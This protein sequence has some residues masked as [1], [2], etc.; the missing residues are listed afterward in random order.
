M[1]NLL[2]SA[3][4]YSIS[5]YGAHSRDIFSSLFFSQKFNISLVIP[6]WGATSNT[7][8]LS[9][10][11]Q[12]AIDFCAHN[13]IRNNSDFI[14]IHIGIPNEF[15]RLGS[16]SV[17]ITAGLEC[18]EIS[19]EWVK[20]SNEID[21]IIVPSTFVKKVFKNSGVT[22]PIYVIPEGVDTN[23]YKVL[24]LEERKLKG[25]EL[26]TKFNFLSCGQ[27]GTPGWDRK[28]IEGLVR[29]FQ[30]TFANNKDIGLILKTF[31]NN[32]SSPDNF[33]TQ[34][35]LNE[36]L[37]SEYPKV[38]LVHGELTDKEM[39]QLYNMADVFIS[40]TSGESWNRPAAEAIACE[41]P[42]MVPNWSGHLDFVLADSDL[43]FNS[44]LVSV[45]SNYLSSGWFTP[46]SKWC[47]PISSEVITKMLKVV[48]N[49]AN[50]K[51]NAIKYAI[52]F[53]AKYN[54]SV[55]DKLV[56]LIDSLEIQEKTPALNLF[57]N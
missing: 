13:R 24:D 4:V 46:N 49:Y 45:P 41:L 48:Q 19:S 6:G 9:P 23:L 40:L 31:I 25:L 22:T 43:L 39:V 37:V 7:W 50:Y 1:K 10:K 20:K 21:L 8:N 44:T 27:W 52:D 53:R 14:Y 16:F 12:G 55:Y 26:T 57:G 54:L 30:K 34:K 33:F 28:Q 29:L 32:I 2:I 15:R 3:P 36:L 11:L 56:E 18:T 38:Y 17:G 42:V 51:Q 5:G 47:L 35:R